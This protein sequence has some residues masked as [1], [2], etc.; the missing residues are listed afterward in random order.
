MI[1]RL[2]MDER[3]NSPCEHHSFENDDPSESLK[4]ATA[5]LS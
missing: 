5:F 1:S 3:F 4:S 2:G